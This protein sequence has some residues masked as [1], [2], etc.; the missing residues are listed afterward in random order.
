MPKASTCAPNF[1]VGN[2][3]TFEITPAM[4]R[5]RR[6]N[7]ELAL[8]QLNPYNGALDALNLYTE[9]IFVAIFPRVTLL[10]VEKLSLLLLGFPQ[11]L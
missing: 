2:D 7:F 6:Q 1:L 5:A 11:L 10:C 8:S 4:D 9:T 3:A